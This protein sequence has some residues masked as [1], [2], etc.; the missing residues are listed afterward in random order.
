M[1]GASSPSPASRWLVLL[2]GVCL[3]LLPTVVAT[4]VHYCDKEADY[5]VTIK[6][7]EITPNP[8]V[9]GKP[10]K[11]SISATAGEAIANGEVMIEVKY[12]GIHVHQET[13]RFC[14]ET[15]CPVSQGDFLVSHDE[16]LPAFT[17]PGSYTLTM[18]M[19][20]EGGAQ[21][22]CVSFDFKIRIGSPVADT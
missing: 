19:F 4:S 7:V 16:V 1:E 21:L 20:G 17:P 13:H 11:F 12:F 2:L 9:R 10:A 15:R 8:V 18:Q 5:P 3:R 22:T 14:E 6:R